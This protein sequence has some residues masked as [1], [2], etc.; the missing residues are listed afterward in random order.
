MLSKKLRGWVPSETV[1]D[2][3]QRLQD[4]SANSNACD[5]RATQSI[6]C[7]HPEATFCDK[8][9]ELKR[10]RTLKPLI[11]VIGLDILLEFCAVNVWTPFVI[12]VIKAFGMPFN[13]NIIA[14]IW[15]PV[16]MIASVCFM[17]T[18][19][20]IGKR[21][22]FLT[23]TGVMVLCCLGLSTP[24]ILIF[25]R[26]SIILFKLSGRCLWLCSLPTKLDVCQES[27]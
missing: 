15:S 20:T 23:S 18:V 24:L 25:I 3:F 12:Q 14:V 21:R 27:I 10:K 2:D 19:K 17:L 5:S 9:K 26:I 22:L 8:I 1:R 11:L 6:R 13:A 16:G 7:Y 4:H